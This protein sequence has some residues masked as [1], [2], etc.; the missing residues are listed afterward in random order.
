MKQN[1]FIKKNDDGKNLVWIQSV[2]T[3]KGEMFRNDSDIPFEEKM[4]ERVRE[5]PLNAEEARSQLEFLEHNLMYYENLPIEINKLKTLLL[6][7]QDEY[8]NGKEKNETTRQL[9]R[10]LRLAIRELNTFTGESKEI[11]S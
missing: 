11:L 1:V 7:L 10:K 6:Q 8:K 5:I 9:A 2:L 3:K 4:K